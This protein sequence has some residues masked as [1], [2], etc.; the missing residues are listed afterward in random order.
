MMKHSPKRI[1]TRRKTREI[2]PP[3][4]NGFLAGTEDIK[5]LFLADSSSVW[6]YV[7]FNGIFNWT[8]WAVY[9]AARGDS[10]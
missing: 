10:F 7:D 8:E 4:I 9:G 5:V 2:W 1:L 6:T 3:V